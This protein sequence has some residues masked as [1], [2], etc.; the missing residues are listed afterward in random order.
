MHARIIAT[1]RVA[2]RTAVAAARA[3]RAPAAAAPR[4]LA[5]PCVSHSTDSILY[6]YPRCKRLTARS[7]SRRS[8]LR[9]LSSTRCVRSEPPASSPSSAAPPGADEARS[10]PEDSP[11]PIDQQ[12]STELPTEEIPAVSSSLDATAQTDAKV[13]AAEPSAEEIAEKVSRTVFVAGLSWSVD[14]EVLREEILRVVEAEEG[15][16]QVRIATD[17]AGRSKG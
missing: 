14:E 17:P 5:P 7:S 2:A 16:N 4:S 13:A 11:A 12:V 6:I 15:V 10:A 9:L 1:S 3:V 8:A